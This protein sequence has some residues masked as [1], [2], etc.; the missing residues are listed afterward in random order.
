MIIDKQITLSN[1][2]LTRMLV[3]TL[4]VGLSVGFV[5]G[6]LLSVLGR[7]VLAGLFE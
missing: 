6:M 2:K 1:F 4:S 3:A 7:L 5:S